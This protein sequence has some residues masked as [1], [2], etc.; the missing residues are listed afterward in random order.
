MAEEF[1]L[2][3]VTSTM[4]LPAGDVITARVVNDS[5]AVEH[6]QVVVYKNTGAG[7]AVVLDTGRL[8]VGAT[9][10]W[11]VTLNLMEPGEFWLR[12]RTSSEALVPGAS[13]DKYEGTEA[14]P[15]MIYRPGDFAVFSLAR[16]RLW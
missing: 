14:K 4:S 15:R 11:F 6:V 13:F 1:A 16:K 10:A 2:E 7:A 8:P 9:W 3:Y 12:I 5:A